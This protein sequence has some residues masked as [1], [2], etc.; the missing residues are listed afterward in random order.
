MVKINIKEKIPKIPIIIACIPALLG[1]LVG[2]LF[3]MTANSNRNAALKYLEEKYK[4]TFVIQNEISY[5][6]CMS[7][8]PY[9]FFIA[10][11]DYDYG[12]IAYPKGYPVNTFVVAQ[13]T[14]QIYDS[15]IKIDLEAFLEETTTKTDGVTPGFTH[16]DAELILKYLEDKYDENFIC[17]EKIT[18]TL[19]MP[20]EHGHLEAVE[21]IR[22]VYMFSPMNNRDVE[23]AAGIKTNAERFDFYEDILN[24]TPAEPPYCD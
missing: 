1:L 20:D 10:E 12:Y 24:P 4:E 18:D 19:A 21:N 2:M 15:Y 3:I 5:N 9:D 23:F 13:F 14:D 22:S 6:A 17:K 8:M 11:E 16:N 7:M